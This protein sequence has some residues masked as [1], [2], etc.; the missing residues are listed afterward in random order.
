MIK[1][2]TN[3]FQEINIYK[4]M[5]KKSEIIS[6]IIYG[7]IISEFYKRKKNG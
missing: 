3:S 5:S 7:E 6:Q 4:G 2:Y 1:N